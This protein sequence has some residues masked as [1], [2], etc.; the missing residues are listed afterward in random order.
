MNSSRILDKV[1]V[2]SA[3]NCGGGLLNAGKT[4]VPNCRFGLG[5]IES[6]G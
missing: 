1:R 4:G 3:G 6:T 2:Y 5:F